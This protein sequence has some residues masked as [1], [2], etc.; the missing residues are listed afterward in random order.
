MSKKSSKINIEMSMP[1][2]CFI[3][4][5]I[6]SVI[7]IL[8]TFFVSLIFSYLLSNSETITDYVFVYLIFSVIIGGFICGFLGSSF[9]PFKGLVSGLICSVPYTIIVYVI[10]FI[11][12]QGN[13][14][15]YSFL[16]PIFIIVSSVVGGITRANLKRRK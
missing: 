13:L 15:T 5:I 14:N 10:M 8:S 3:G 16:L 4:L 7:G 1:L 11:F 9:L 12:S 2:K 6:S